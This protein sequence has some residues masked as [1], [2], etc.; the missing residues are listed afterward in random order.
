MNKVK[1]L[2]KIFEGFSQTK[3]AIQNAIQ[4]ILYKRYVS[5]LKK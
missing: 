4:N 1:V 2:L 5:V 3:K